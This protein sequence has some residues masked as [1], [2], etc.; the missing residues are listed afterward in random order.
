MRISLLYLNTGW[1][2][3]SRILVMLLF[4]LSFPR[5]WGRNK[6]E[7]TMKQKEWKR[8]KLSIFFFNQL[9]YPV[10]HCSLY[11]AISQLLYHL[12]TTSLPERPLL[13]G[14]S[15]TFRFR[16][17]TGSLQSPLSGFCSPLCPCFTRTLCFWAQYSQGIC[18]SSEFFFLS[19]ELEMLLLFL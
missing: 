17:G 13:T 5:I 6:T 8:G 9:F 7:L 12:L 15:S 16:A 3:Y 2:Q 19:R 10:Y 11:P 18:V 1:R 4:L 14:I